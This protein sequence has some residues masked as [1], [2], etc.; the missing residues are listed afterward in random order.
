[1]NRLRINHDF[2][3]RYLGDSLVLVCDKLFSPAYTTSTYSELLSRI[4]AEYNLIKTYQNGDFYLSIPEYI[5]C[6]ELVQALRIHKFDPAFYKPNTL[7]YH[8]TYTIADY[9]YTKVFGFLHRGFSSISYWL[10]PYDV[11]KDLYCKNIII[12]FS[13]FLVYSVS[14][15]NVHLLYFCAKV[16]TRVKKEQQLKQ[17]KFE[18]H[19]AKLN[20][21]IFAH[22]PDFNVRVVCTE[23]SYVL[24]C[25]EPLDRGFVGVL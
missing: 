2:S 1:M 10:K 15:E 22:A 7:E 20:K 16:I 18:I 11:E 8:Q 13:L 21:S 6:T 25:F 9:P 24:E 19:Q 5:H 23:N 4:K 17:V 12:Y 3:I 14:E